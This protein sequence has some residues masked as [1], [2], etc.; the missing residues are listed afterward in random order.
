MN[1]IP[2]KFLKLCPNR[3]Q[4]FGC[5]FCRDVFP[6]K[7]NRLVFGKRIAAMA[8]HPIHTTSM[9]CEIDSCNDDTI[10]FKAL[11]KVNPFKEVGWY[12]SAQ[13][14]LSFSTTNAFPM[15]EA[16]SKAFSL[17]G[18]F[19]DV[20][21]DP[22][23]ITHPNQVSLWLFRMLATNF[24]EFKLLPL[25]SLILLFSTLSLPLLC[26]LVPILGVIVVLDKPVPDD[27]PRSFGLTFRLAMVR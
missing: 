20:L 11:S 21:Q 13:N 17:S 27:K 6:S 22:L 8:E 7:W 26:L 18:D 12:W 2:K 9:I 10:R 3:S 23:L 1:K 24:I 15:N 19:F 25:L 4:D 5:K 16:S 14:C